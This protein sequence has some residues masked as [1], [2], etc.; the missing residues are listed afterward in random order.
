MTKKVASPAGK[1]LFALATVGF[2]AL[3][4]VLATTYPATLAGCLSF[5]ALFD[6]TCTDLT[7]ATSFSSV[8]SESV[9]C[10][11]DVK[12]CAGSW[13]STGSTCTWTR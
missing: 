8:A 13:D 10:T 5:A 9:S 7:T 1:S 3:P 2:L 4:S 11:G 12:Y 6:N